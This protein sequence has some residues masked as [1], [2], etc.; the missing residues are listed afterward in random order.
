MLN[1]QNWLIV[2]SALKPQSQYCKAIMTCVP[3][4]S[5]KRRDRPSRER[6]GPEPEH[7]EQRRERIE[8]PLGDTERLKC[9]QPTGE[10]DGVTDIRRGDQEV[11]PEGQAEYRREY[12]ACGK[13]PEQDLC[14]RPPA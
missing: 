7:E 13:D 2:S 4:R 9:N 14:W 11:E 12:Q 6:Q 8:R 5:G 10:I 3:T 1:A